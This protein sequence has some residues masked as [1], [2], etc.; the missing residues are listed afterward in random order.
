[1]TIL[2]MNIYN[3]IAA[4][5]EEKANTRVL[6]RCVL[7]IRDKLQERVEQRMGS[8]VKFSDFYKALNQLYWSGKI[9]KGDTATDE[10]VQIVYKEIQS[11]L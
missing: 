8:P 1:M 2:E 10:Y 4:I 6:P 5:E 9:Q 11:S 3:T 7:L